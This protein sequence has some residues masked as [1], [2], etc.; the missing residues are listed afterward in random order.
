[1]LSKRTFTVAQDQDYLNAICRGK[2]YYFDPSWNHSAVKGALNDGKA[3]S[4][5]HYKMDWKPWHHDG[6]LFEDIFW[7][8][9]DASAFAAD[10][11]AINAAYTEAEQERDHAA[12]L[13]LIEVARAETTALLQ[14]TSIVS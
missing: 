11:R 7:Q 12:R 2:V 14:T 3:P 1:M 10:I 6:V 4:I 8:Y 13:H 9:A 5:I